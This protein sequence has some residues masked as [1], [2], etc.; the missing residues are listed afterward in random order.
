[1]SLILI[2]ANHVS[3]QER[4]DVLGIVGQHGGT[5]Q[6][7]ECSYSV[8]TDVT[9]EHLTH[10]LKERACTTEGIQILP[11]RGCGMRSASE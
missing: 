8:H 11:V 6:L 1:M 5:L 3:S 10:E 2:F 9:P 4:D 7:S